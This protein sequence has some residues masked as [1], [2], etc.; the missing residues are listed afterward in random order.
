MKVQFEIY[1][2]V[3][4]TT[5]RFTHHDNRSLFK[6]LRLEILMEKFPETNRLNIYYNNTGILH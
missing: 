1:E 4:R 3:L 6:G 2:I 5:F